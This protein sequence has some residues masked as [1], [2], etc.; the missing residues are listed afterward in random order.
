MS[1]IIKRVL[2]DFYTLAEALEASGVSRTAMW[3]WQRSGRLKTYPLGRETL[4]RKA[5]V[6]R[7][8]RERES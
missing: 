7:I 5:D 6:E 1:T 2:E 3:K 4:I 8:R